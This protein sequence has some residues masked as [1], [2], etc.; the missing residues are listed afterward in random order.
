MSP[1]LKGAW[2]EEQDIGVRCTRVPSGLGSYLYDPR[3][4]IAFLH[5]RR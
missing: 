3:A 5:L 4:R 1:L 2:P